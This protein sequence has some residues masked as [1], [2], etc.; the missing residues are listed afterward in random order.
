MTLHPHAIGP[1]PEETARVAHAACPKGNPYLH[2]R[3]LLG[4]LYDDQQF[5]ALF[6]SQGQPAF[7]PWRLAL[8]TIMQFA[9]GLS[10]RQAAEAVRVRLDWKYAINLE[11]TDPGFDFSILCEF[12]TRLL[13]KG[14]EQL[15]F[16]TMLAQ[17]KTQGL[18]KSRGRQ[19]TDS[20][21][22][23]AAIRTLNRLECVGETMRHALESLAVV[24]PA[25]LLQQVR[26]EWKERYE[27]RI[28]E[29]RLP[30]SKAE[31]QAL[32]ETI[33]ADGFALLT[34]MS[35]ASA[36][37]W[38]R[39]VPALETLRRVWI[40]QFYAP[41]GPVR[42]RSNED[43]PPSAVLIQSPHD[44]E[45][46][47]GTKRTM[48][49]TGYKVHLTETCEADQPN[50]IT[51]VETTDATVPDT[52]LLDPI[53]THLAE[54][55][56]LPAEHLVDAGYVDAG[57]LVTAATAHQVEVIGPVRADTNWQ[58]RQGQGFAAS[59]F[60]IDWEAKSVQCPQGKRSVTWKERIDHLGHD[61][62][63]IAFGWA[64][65]KHCPV[66]SACTQK[67]QGSRTMK[68][69]SQAQCLAL[70]AA[71]QRQRTPEFR[72]QY[73]KRAGIEGTL[74]QGVRRS[75]MRRSRYIGL[76]RTHLQHVLTAAALNLV[77]A[78]AWL[79]KTPRVK[80]RPSRFAALLTAG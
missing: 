68:L 31:R 11:L 29:Y 30:E 71:R 46:R 59:C 60:V 20:T 8:V 42:W 66:R 58:A 79:I 50:L 22:I 73:R 13:T 38:L 55:D 76:A 26:P 35:D 39:E 2:M 64:D 21:H 15:L 51:N 7:A 47:Y 28:Q 5:A 52:E 67:K 43:L 61:V 75:E 70:Y 10:D 16:E 41:D 48:N 49:W 34:A 62:I 36:P 37:T 78:V 74:S 53:H 19:R 25:W 9:E 69:L 80:T 12:R 24:A 6:P 17:F 32:A 3:D 54:H 63:D 14:A 65:C 44:V 57:I 33:G 27:H 4:T 1:V 18:L 77:R 23:L 40:Q 45:A 56:L 72:E